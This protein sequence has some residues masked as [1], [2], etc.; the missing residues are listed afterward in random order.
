MN[1]EGTNLRQREQASKG[2]RADPPTARK[3][4]TNRTGEP[5]KRGRERAKRRTK[6]R[7]K[8]KESE[9]GRPRRGKDNREGT[10]GGGKEKADRSSRAKRDNTQRQRQERERRG[11]K[12]IPTTTRHERGFVRGG[13]GQESARR[14]RIKGRGARRRSARNIRRQRAERGA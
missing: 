8:E 9:R 7:T 3:H 6:R 11:N 4:E 14:I 10:R 2:R 13:Q 5:E 12:L 1:V